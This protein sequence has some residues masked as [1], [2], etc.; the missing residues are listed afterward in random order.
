MCFFGEVLILLHTLFN[1]QPVTLWSNINVIE[2]M[3]ALN[4]Y[5]YAELFKLKKIKGDTLVELDE[6]KLQVSYVK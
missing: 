5:R 6:S 1:L 4:L 3:A 2:W